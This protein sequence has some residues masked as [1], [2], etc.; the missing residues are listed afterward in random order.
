MQAAASIQQTRPTVNQAIYSFATAVADFP[1]AMQKTQDGLG[2][3][4]ATSASNGSQSVLTGKSDESLELGPGMNGNVD[5]QE[6]EL[7]TKL[8]DR[9]ARSWEAMNP[10]LVEDFLSSVPDSLRLTAATELIVMD[11]ERRNSANLPFAVEDYARRF[12]ELS[13]QLQ[14]LW[15]AGQSAVRTRQEASTWD[16][17]GKEGVLTK[18]EVPSRKSALAAEASPSQETRDE[19]VSDQSSRFGPFQIS[20]ELGRGGLRCCTSRMSFVLSRGLAIRTWPSFMSY[21][22]TAPCG[23]LRWS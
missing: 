14:K 7:L 16:S 23:S 2:R 11:W 6:A 9:F 20:E 12:P 4:S 13:D 19:P 5:V 1:K 10:P 8:Y 18:S 22:A 3:W 15:D 17:T 21:S